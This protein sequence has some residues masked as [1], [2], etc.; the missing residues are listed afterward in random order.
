[1]FAQFVAV[2]E[3]DCTNTLFKIAKNKEYNIVGAMTHI[4]RWCDSAEGDCRG[5]ARWSELKW[6]GVCYSVLPQWRGSAEG[7]CR[8]GVS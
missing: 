6:V 4:L 7:D 5:R 2:T 3:I 8:G 1:V